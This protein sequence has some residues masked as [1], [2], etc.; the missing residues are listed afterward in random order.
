[1]TNAHRPVRILAKRGD[2]PWTSA[3]TRRGFLGAVGIAGVS[4]A[5]AACGSGGSGTST[6]K[7]TGGP[8][9]DKLNIYTWSDYDNPDV[10]KA[11]TEKYGP[12]LTLDSYGSNEEMIAKLVAAKGT[13]GYDIV[14]PSGSHVPQMIENGLLE[15][16]NKSLL[17]NLKHVDPQFLG[18]SWDPDNTY[19]VCKDWGTT[20]YV[21]DQT[22]IR[23]DLK[24]WADFLDAA[25]HEASGKTSMLDDPAEITGPYFWSHD[26]P[27]T[28]TN[29]DDLDAAETFVV[30]SLAPHISAFDSAPGSTAIPQATHALIQAYNGDA[31]LGITNS[32]DP[33]RWKWVFPGPRTELWMDNWAIATGAGHPEAAHAFINSILEPTNA[34]QELEHTGY[35][36][37]VSGIEAAAREAGVTMLDMIFFTPAQVAT[38][39]DGGVNEAQQRQVDIWNKAKAAAGA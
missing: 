25:Q 19:T 35:N 26:I 23:R 7:A 10:L 6:V 8:V 17:P 1:M 18:R 37:G 12:T 4:A 14:V 31:R 39:E 22:V 16:F 34:L 28:T 32:P 13:S 30:E 27:W 3:L 24:N 33:Q 15:P 11:F 29:N 2:L 21:Y 38:M 9:E 5:V 36:T 20:G